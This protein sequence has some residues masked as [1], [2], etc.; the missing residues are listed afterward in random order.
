MIDIQLLSLTQRIIAKENISSFEIASFGHPTTFL[1]SNHALTKGLSA[2]ETKSINDVQ[3]HKILKE[4][5]DRSISLYSF[6]SIIEKMNCTIRKLH[7]YDIDPR[8]DP[9]LC[10]DLNVKLPQQCFNQYDLAIDSGTHEHVF[11]IGNSL[12]NFANLPKSNG[13]AVGVLPY[14]SPNHGFYNV[15]PNCIGELFC[16]ANGY[17]L[18]S[19]VI[20]GY[21]SPMH[22]LLG[23]IENRSIVYNSSD[24]ETQ[25]EIWDTI[26]R[27]RI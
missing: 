11:N 25:A 5:F 13:Y 14:F 10:W 8:K 2:C 6:T 22:G 9:F 7:I 23:H 1:P 26:Q 19:I 16:L 27:H 4:K 21:K 12:I 15:N 17:R 24:K 20:N 3:L 18:L